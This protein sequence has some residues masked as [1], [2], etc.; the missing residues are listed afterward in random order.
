MIELS[1]LRLLGDCLDQT[2]E[3]LLRR[4]PSGVWPTPF[5]GPVH[6][7]GVGPQLGAHVPTHHPFA[8]PAYGT[9][10]GAGV[11]GGGWRAGYPEQVG[12]TPWGVSPIEIA[13]QRAA[14]MYARP[15]GGSPFQPYGV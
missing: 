3:M 12:W 7:W 9:P 4:Q 8:Q 10:W 14:A 5:G 1:N 2:I 13:R 11:H 15:F 6:P